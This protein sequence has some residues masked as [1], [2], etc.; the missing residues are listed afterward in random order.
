MLV[1]EQS[2]QLNE[3]PFES[4]EAYEACGVG[5]VDAV[6]VV[7]AERLDSRD[8]CFCS[9]QQVWMASQFRSI[10]GPPGVPIKISTKGF[11]PSLACLTASSSPSLTAKC[12]VSARQT[13]IKH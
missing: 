7:W 8:E 10:I 5:L 11:S 12:S 2:G 6:G 13:V 9:P 1:R 4:G 3:I